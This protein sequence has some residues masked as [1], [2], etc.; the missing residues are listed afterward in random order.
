M[1]G[2]RYNSL[3]TASNAVVAAGQR[4]GVA[5][6]AAIELED[7]SRRWEV[8]L[9][10]P[11]VKGGTAIDRRGRVLVSLRDSSIVCYGEN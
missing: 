2:E 1:P 7:G 6:L 5:F 11:A 10:S 9:S 3:V 8:M 4:G